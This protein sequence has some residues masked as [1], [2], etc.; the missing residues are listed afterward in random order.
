MHSN[1]SL[2]GQYADMLP[3]NDSYPFLHP[4]V[5]STTVLCMP[6]FFFFFQGK[7]PDSE[8]LS[9]LQTTASAPI[10]NVGGVAP[11]HTP[12]VYRIPSATTSYLQPLSVSISLNLFLFEIHWLCKFEMY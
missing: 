5:I 4:L 3:V 10:L 8:N 7:V 9:S 2:R 11:A 12:H 6:Y 1:L